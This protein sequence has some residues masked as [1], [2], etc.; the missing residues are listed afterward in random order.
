VKEVV[1]SRNRF[2]SRFTQADIE[3][4]AKVDEAH[5]MLSGPATKK[6]LERKRSIWKRD[7]YARLATA[8]IAHI[9]NLRKRRRYRECRMNYTKMRAV[10]VAIGERRKP[11]P[12]GRPGYLRV[13]TV[14]QGDWMESRVCTISTLSTR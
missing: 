4:L 12:G 8:S 10:Q 3:L 2:Q 1:Y 6:I 14:H 7:G 13:D 5:E 11:E 9:Y